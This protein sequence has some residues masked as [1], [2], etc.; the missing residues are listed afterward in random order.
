M[1]AQ[2]QCHVAVIG[3]GPAGSATALLLRRA[4]WR[5][6]LLE[7]ARFPRDKLCGEFISAEGVAALTEIGLGTW[8][9]EHCPQIARVLVTSRRG[10]VWQESLSGRAVGCSRA[11][12]DQQ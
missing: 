5:V 9:A 3:A 10:P 12:L 1:S 8:M 6:T 11:A 4:G 2:P 7:R